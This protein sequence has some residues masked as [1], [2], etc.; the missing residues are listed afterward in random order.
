M[1]PKEAAPIPA[2]VQP[3]G[4]FFSLGVDI[5]GLAAL[6][7]KLYAYAP[8]SEKVVEEIQKSVKRLVGDAGWTGGDAN[9]FEDAWGA[10]ASDAK[11]LSM[12]T[13][14]AAKILDDLASA[15]AELQLAANNRKLEYERKSTK[16]ANDPQVKQDL[17][18]ML[19]N[20]QDKARDMQSDA[21]KNLV[22]LYSGEKKGA[23][24]VLDAVKARSKDD[25]VSKKLRD[26]LGDVEDDLDD[27]L[28]DDDFPWT[29]FVSWV[30]GGA[31]IGAAIGSFGGG[32][33][34]IP[35][36]VVGGGVGLV[37]G[38]VVGGGKWTIDQFDDWF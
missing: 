28:P 14:D 27:G 4:G 15:L 32:I 35:G 31:G 18:V 3:V 22:S 17:A 10:D 33:G 8:A 26:K 6:A 25:D 36:G 16:P 21:A 37:A 20:A 12:F 23:W 29:D 19:R 13:D 24:S 7:T 9:S 1:A 34:A 5:R 30:G 38:A 2:G 11:K